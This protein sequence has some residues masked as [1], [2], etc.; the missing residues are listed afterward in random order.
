[1]SDGITKERAREIVAAEGY[2]ERVEQERVTLAKKDA[3]IKALV[4]A[5]E[6]IHRGTAEIAL[7]AHTELRIMSHLEKEAVAGAALAQA[8][9]HLEGQVKP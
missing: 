7:G 4:E 9:E 6:K 2:L 1:M 3:L 8:R 5:L